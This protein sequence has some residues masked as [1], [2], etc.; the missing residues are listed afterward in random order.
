MAKHQAPSGQDAV[1]FAL[2]ELAE[3]KNRVQALEGRRLNT[4]D[5]YY[6]TEVAAPVEG[7][8]VVEPVTEVPWWYS[9]GQWRTF[10]STFDVHYL[11]A[12]AG[13][14]TSSGAG[15]PIAWTDVD[16]TSGSVF[17][18]TT[19][20]DSNDTIQF[21]Q[22]GIYVS[23]CSA[24]AE[25]A[26]TDWGIGTQSSNL[27]PTNPV[28]SPFLAAHQIDYDAGEAMGEMRMFFATGTTGTIRVTI[29]EVRAGSMNFDNAGLQ[30]IYLPTSATS[31]SDIG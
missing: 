28:V 26:G 24:G 11:A 19:V 3:L 2:R 18:V 20:T 25:T 7:Q 14:F 1:D 15:D 9:D 4:W 23:L 16:T 13:T 8:H 12:T 21:K 10:T 5:R 6:H 17:G 30:V 29:T 27:S 31:L 22:A